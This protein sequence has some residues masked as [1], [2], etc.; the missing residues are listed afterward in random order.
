MSTVT[1]K[2]RLKPDGQAARLLRWLRD[3]QGSTS[4]QITQA[5]FVVNV[6]GRVSDLRR[7]GYRIDCRKDPQGHDAYYVVERDKPEPLTGEQVGMAL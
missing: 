4:L 5:L 6:T 7:A 2:P 1:D 3:H